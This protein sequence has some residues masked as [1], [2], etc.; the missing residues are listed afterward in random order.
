MRNQLEEQNDT[1]DHLRMELENAGGQRGN[2][3]Q[4]E[5]QW[6]ED[7]IGFELTIAQNI[8]R[9]NALENE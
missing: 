6:E 5:D 3:N 7:K 4:D 2:E 9:I 1:I 8:E